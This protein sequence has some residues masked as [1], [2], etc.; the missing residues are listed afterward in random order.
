MVLGKRNRAYDY[1]DL[2]LVELEGVE[3]TEDAK[4]KVKI[5]TI[6]DYADVEKIQ[7]ELRHGNLVWTRIKPLKDK[8][9][10]ELK[11]AIDKLKKTILSINGDI[12][13]VD[14]NY[15]ILSPEGVRISR[16]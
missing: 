6:N 7:N 11:R 10:T 1:D 15:L 3:A 9:I 16:D 4:M 13:G 8:D 14:E 5:I 12:A 2:D